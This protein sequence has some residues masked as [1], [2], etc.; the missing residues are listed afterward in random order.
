M[1]TS[2]RLNPKWLHNII[3]LRGDSALLILLPLGSFRAFPVFGKSESAVNGVKLIRSFIVLNDQALACVVYV[4]LSAFHKN[5]NTY[6][7]LATWIIHFVSKRFYCLCTCISYACRCQRFLLCF[8][9]IVL[10][11]LQLAQQS[12]IALRWMAQQQLFIPRTHM[13]CNFM[14]LLWQYSCVLLYLEAWK[15]S[16]RSL[17]LSWSLSYFHCSAYSSGFLLLRGK[18]LQVSVSKLS[19]LRK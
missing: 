17:L 1:P 14:G 5:V 16:T 11:M 7:F 9:Y 19:L 12:Q 6:T 18:M 3:L 13:I 15:W 8:K 2:Y 10:L 4:S